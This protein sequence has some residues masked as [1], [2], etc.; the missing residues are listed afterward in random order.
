MEPIQ[1]PTEDVPIGRLAGN[2]RFN[3][4]GKDGRIFGFVI[5]DG[6]C[7]TAARRMLRG[8]GTIWFRPDG[9][10]SVSSPSEW[11]CTN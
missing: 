1:K 3:P 11:L 2:P 8:L 9:A 10:W 5:S 4:G 7:S 6:R